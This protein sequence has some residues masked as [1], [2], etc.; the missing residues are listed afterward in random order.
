M[1]L[2]ELEFRSLSMEHLNHY[3]PMQLLLELYT[4]NKNLQDI[5]IELRCS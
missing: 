2:L 3:Q 1:C 5:E 4:K